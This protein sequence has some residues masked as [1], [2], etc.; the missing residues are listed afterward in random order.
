M[1]IEFRPLHVL[2]ISCCVLRDC[3]CVIV[4]HKFVDYIH[5]RMYIGKNEH[6]G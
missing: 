5:G 2:Y 1:G 4:C 3:D 6:Y